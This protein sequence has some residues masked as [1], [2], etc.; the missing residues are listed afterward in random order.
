MKSNATQS[1]DTHSRAE[2]LQR[3]L[4]KTMRPSDKADVVRQLVRA[5]HSMA[6]AGA[7]LRHPAASEAELHKM[8]AE[9]WYGA[10]VLPEHSSETSRQGSR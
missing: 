5:C 2:I 8:V 4:W 1:R 10:G 6:L 7:R 3:E 9:L